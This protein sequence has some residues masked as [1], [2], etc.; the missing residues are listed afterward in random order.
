MPPVFGVGEDELVT[1]Y[2]TGPGSRWAPLAVTLSNGDVLV[3]GGGGG[4][5]FETVRA[6]SVVYRPSRNK[7]TIGTPMQFARYNGAWAAKLPRN[8][9]ILIAGGG[10]G[11]TGELNATG[12]IYDPRTKSWELLPTDGGMPNDGSVDPFDSQLVVRRDGTVQIT[13]GPGREDV[14]GASAGSWILQVK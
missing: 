1:P 4:I 13:G 10:F 11:P 5:L 3:A 8:A 14:F 6:S 12:E 7:W 2:P 9:G